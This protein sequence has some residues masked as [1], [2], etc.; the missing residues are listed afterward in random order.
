MATVER[1]PRPRTITVIAS[2]YACTCE[3]C[4]NTG[5]LLLKSKAGDLCLDCGD[6]GHLEFLPSGDAAL[7]RRARKASRQCVLIVRWNIRRNRYERQGILAE[8]AAIE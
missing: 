8:P 7:S 6:L 1:P 2:Q 5:D 3:S 4:G